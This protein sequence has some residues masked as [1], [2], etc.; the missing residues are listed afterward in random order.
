MSVSIASVPCQQRSFPPCSTAWRKRTRHR[1]HLVISLHSFLRST[2]PLLRHTIHLEFLL[3][4]RPPRGI[5]R[6]IRLNFPSLTLSKRACSY[7]RSAARPA[8][9]LAATS[10]DAKV[11]GQACTRAVR[12]GISA[13][14][15]STHV[16]S[17]NTK[18]LRQT[19]Q[20]S[21]LNF[22]TYRAD[23]SDLAAPRRDGTR[24]AHAP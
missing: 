22:Y 4:P 2:L 14:T 23:S 21:T 10:A 1:L 11:V 6:S 5:P 19:P 18:Q 24:P 9:Y 16:S 13:S 12:C 8:T 7:P 20:T 15:A 17:A 3:L